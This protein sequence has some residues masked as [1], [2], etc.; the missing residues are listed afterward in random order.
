MP[1]LDS[2][3]PS[4]SRSLPADEIHPPVE[5]VQAE[6]KQL[7]K[8]MASADWDSHRAHQLELSRAMRFPDNTFERI[9]RRISMAVFT[10]KQLEMG[11]RILREIGEKDSQVRD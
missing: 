8:E 10:A 7:R 3:C 1:K 9:T 6:L 5:V 4:C 2:Q 11:E